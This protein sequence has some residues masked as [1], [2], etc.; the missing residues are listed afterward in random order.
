VVRHAVAVAALLALVAGCGGSGEPNKA[1]Y[2]ARVAAVCGRYGRQLD[3]IPPPGDIAAPGDIVD[4]VGRALPILRAQ[5][6]TIRALQVPHELRSRL[7][8][9]FALT[10]SSIA[11]LAEALQ[12]ARVRDYGEIGQGEVRFSRARDAAKAIATAIGLRC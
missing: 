8:R 2:L 7:R 3:Q 1:H 11:G 6:R 9:F 12:G 5:A 4:S 10:D